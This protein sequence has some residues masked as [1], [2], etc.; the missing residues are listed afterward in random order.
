[1][2]A[3]FLFVVLASAA[4]ALFVLM[5]GAYLVLSRDLV[6][7]TELERITFNQESLIYDRT[8]KV[9]LARF[10][11]VRRDVVT[12][13][14]IPDF[15]LDATT[16]IEDKSFW[17]NTG[18]DPAGIAAAAL[19]TLRGRSRG[20]ST[21][22]QQLV[23]Q[24]L[25]DEE[26]VQ[27]PDRRAERKL[28]E[29]IQSVRLTQAYPGEEG[30]RRVIT[31]YL[32]QNFYGSN[33]YGV[34]AA[35]RTYF[36]V[37]DLQDLTLAQAAILAALPQS[38]SEYDLTRGAVEECLEPG[39]TAEGEPTCAKAQLVVPEDAPIVERRN[40]VLNLMEQGRTPLSGDRFSARDFDAAREEPV[41]LSPQT[42]R[43]WLAPHFVW[44]VQGELATTL[45]GEE[46]TTC[47][48]LEAGGLRVTSTL[49]MRLQEIADRW[50]KA[51]VILPKH[52]NPEAYA[53]RIGVSFQPWMENLA[54][55]ELNNGALVALDYQT[56]EVLAYVGSADYD[57]KPR[58]AFQPKFDVLSQGWRQAGSAFKPVTY[59]TGID[60]GRVTAASMLMDVV[61]D[62]GG[63]YTPTDADELERGP[64]RA[65]S[66]LQ[67]SLNIPAIKVLAVTGVE[68]VARRGEAMGLRFRSDAAGAGL[69]LTLGTQ[70]TRPIDLTTAY[71][72][73][74]NS[75]QYVPH[76]RILRVT[77]QGGQDVVPPYQPP[78]AEPVVSPQAAYLVTD[79]LAGNTDPRVNP[80]WGRFMLS[81]GEARRPATLK[82]G[83][84]NDAKDLNV[85]GYIAPPTEE[86]REAGEHALVVGAWNGNSDN[87][88]VSTPDHPVFS[89]DVTT[90]VWQGFMQQATKGWT[91]NDFARPDRITERRVDP[92]TGLLA[93]E[94]GP[95]VVELFVAGTEPTPV[96]FAPGEGGCAVN[97]GVLRVAGFEDHHPTWL[98]AD[99][100]WL[101]R[102]RRGPGVAGGPEDTRTSYFYNFEFR[103]YG[104]SWGALVSRRADGGAG[105]GS[106]ASPG[107]SPT[108][109]C[110]TPSPSPECPSPGVSAS[111]TPDPATTTCPSPSPTETPS[112]SPTETLA[113]LPTEVPTL[114]PVPTEAPTLPP[115]PEPTPTLPVETPTTEPSVDASAPAG[116]EA[117]S[118][119]PP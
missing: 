36:G 79:I 5:V 20:G 57:G 48:E 40:Q 93:R 107:A 54:D 30:K 35:A 28:T 24:R 110:A 2:L 22:T 63:G 18:F 102:A 119:L 113:P 34:K 81:E 68:E 89:I 26:L 117:P 72:T 17:T 31:A 45:C 92:W 69:S 116:A 15:L 13:D 114:P 74:A 78:T 19:D 75:G 76:T 14:Q 104:A 62:F 99:R 27:D 41:V 96:A 118:E 21:I 43:R 82:T 44:A 98:E 88:L 106:P 84:N 46:A 90:H 94:G 86:G 6:D 4:L 67:F 50:V 9:E 101:R 23:R 59:A 55:K 61:T 1:M 56:G 111:L 47:P 11:A 65:R 10:G 32:N 42:A 39:E 52:R 70:E 58:P 87:S 25:L 16:A 49:D 33:S 60:T 77:D 7:P 66:A 109:P 37:E 112:P 83:T 103:P 73:L 53:K 38:P 64:V 100:E 3:P 12:F 80:Y 91:V 97:E 85:Y 95:S 115:P 71:G 29:I 105:G 51:A 8:G 108:D